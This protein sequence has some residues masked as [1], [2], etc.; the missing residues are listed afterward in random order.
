MTI[1]ILTNIMLG[2]LCAGA[3]VILGVCIQQLIWECI[4]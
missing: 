1:P 2:A 4:K 3:L